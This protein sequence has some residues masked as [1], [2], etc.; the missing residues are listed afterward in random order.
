MSLTM[1]VQR[2]GRISP[3]Y[4]QQQLLTFWEAEQKRVMWLRFQGPLHA[5]LMLWIGIH[6]HSYESCSVEYEAKNVWPPGS[7]VKLRAGALV[8]ST[9]SAANVR[10]NA[11]L[12]WTG[13]KSFNHAA[14]L[15]FANVIS[16]NRLHFWYWKKSFCGDCE[17]QK[18]GSTVLQPF[19]SQCKLLSHC[20]YT[21]W[22]LCLIGFK[23]WRFSKGPL[24]VKPMFL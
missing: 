9:S 20:N 11:P 6:F 16:L 24:V 7:K 4:N 19:R 18:N 1:V 3:L 10:F 14:L 2:N 8:T 23:A 13:I 12:T 5:M 21:V 17:A 22:P 15:D